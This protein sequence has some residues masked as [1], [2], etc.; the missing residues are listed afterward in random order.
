MASG[1]ATSRSGSRS[2]PAGGMAS[3]RP[4]RCAA[5]SL[6]SL[7]LDD[8]DGVGVDT[9]FLDNDEDALFGQLAAEAEHDPPAK[10]GRAAAR[11]AVEG[12]PT[13]AVAE[14]GGAAQ[15]AVCKDG[16]EAGEAARRLPCVHLYHG[17]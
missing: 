9:Y 3:S 6:G 10:G 8:D 17:A 7:L 11:D 4:P 14:S 16:I 13:V 5:N 15:C 2:P 12:L 1:S